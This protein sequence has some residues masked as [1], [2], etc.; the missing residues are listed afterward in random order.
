MAMFDS[1]FDITR[2]Y[3]FLVI[4]SPA[5]CI[6]LENMEKHPL[7]GAT[8]HTFCDKLK[9]GPSKE[10]TG[11]TAQQ[12]IIRTIVEQL[13]YCDRMP[14]TIFPIGCMTVIMFLI[15]CYPKNLMLLNGMIPLPS[16]NDSQFAIEAMAQSIFWWGFPLKRLPAAIPM[17]PTWKS[18]VFSWKSHGDLNHSCHSYANVDQ[19]W[20][21]ADL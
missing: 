1:Y 16:N 11:N 3:C 5:T 19:C 20:P 2:G 4:T 21:E 15:H 6:C 14:V 8:Q 9:H 13:C 18:W 10:P 12:K 7:W 17:V